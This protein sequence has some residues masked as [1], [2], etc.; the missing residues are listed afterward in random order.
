M[1]PSA[2][3]YQY[4]SRLS[5]EAI[6]STEGVEFR[7]DDDQSGTESATESTFLTTYAIGI[8]TGRVDLFCG[9]RY[10]PSDLVNSWPV[11]HWG[12]IIAARWLCS[13]RANP[14]PDSILMMYDEVMEDLKDVQRGVLSIPDASPRDETWPAWSNVIV[15]QRYWS[16][17][18]VRVQR[19]ISERDSVGQQFRSRYSAFNPSG[20]DRS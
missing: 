16:E 11:W 8:A 18:K 3:T 20:F 19:F 9:S 15:D 5:I 17:A 1:A 12:T 13:R 2:Q 10:Q 4:A 14:N 6:L 7:L